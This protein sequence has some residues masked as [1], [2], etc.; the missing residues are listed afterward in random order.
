MKIND[1]EFYDRILKKASES[2][3]AL[4]SGVAVKLLYHPM[5]LICTFLCMACVGGTLEGGTPFFI[6]LLIGYAASYI[7][8]LVPTLIAYA[9][10][11]NF[12]TVPPE[13]FGEILWLMDKGYALYPNHILLQQRTIRAEKE[14]K[15]GFAFLDGMMQELQNAGYTK[16]EVECLRQGF[17]PVSI[18]DR[19]GMGFSRMY[20]RNYDMLRRFV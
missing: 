7:G 3:K 8:I 14:M 5:T 15:A 9:M 17:I 6:G 20:E 10:M 13:Q 2:N 19:C 16:E 12:A 1:P 4:V 11:G 18:T